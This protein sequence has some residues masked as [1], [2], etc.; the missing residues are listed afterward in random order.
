MTNETRERLTIDE[1]PG[2]EPEI[3]LA[4]AMLEETR[5]RTKA[6]LAGIGVRSAC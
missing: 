2:Y 4:L 5:R 1:L 3:G 6:M